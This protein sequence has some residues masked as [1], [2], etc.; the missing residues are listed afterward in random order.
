MHPQSPNGKPNNV[1]S[2]QRLPLP[3]GSIR[4]RRHFVSLEDLCDLLVLCATEPEAADQLFLAAADD[5]ISTP[6]LIAAIAAALGRRAAMFP[7]PP[8]DRTRCGGARRH[9]PR[10]RANDVVAARRRVACARA[11]RLGAANRTAA[12]DRHNGTGFLIGGGKV[13]RSCATGARF[14][15]SR[16]FCLHVAGD[17]IVMVIACGISAVAR[18]CSTRSVLR[19]RFRGTRA[20]MSSRGY[21]AEV[22]DDLSHAGMC[23]IDRVGVQRKT[24]YHA[25]PNGMLRVV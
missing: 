17:S 18:C 5:A 15:Q 11:A 10:A 6:D 23:G 4:N 20:P 13:P 16:R 14:G 25:P 24:R 21:G 2:K 8:A 19:R 3:L 12:S 22:R 9:A 1:C 7:L